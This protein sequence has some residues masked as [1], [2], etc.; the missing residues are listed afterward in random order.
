MTRLQIAIITIAA[1]AFI[2]SF[3]GLSTFHHAGIA[4][5]LMPVEKLNEQFLVGEV[6]F[7]PQDTVS[8]QRRFRKLL[9]DA[10]FSTDRLK[11]VTGIIALQ[12]WIGNQVEKTEPYWGNEQGFQLLM[13]GMNGTGLACSSMSVIFR[14]ALALLETPARIVQIYRSGSNINNTHVL[15]EVNI[16][17]KWVA[18]D[19]TYN[20][21]YQYENE[22][23][24][25]GQI[26]KALYQST[27]KEIELV[28]HGKRKY[29]ASFKA[30]SKEWK[31]VFNNALIAH[32]Q[33][34]G[35]SKIVC[36]VGRIPPFRY[37]WGPQ[38]YFY[39]NGLILFLN[40]HNTLYFLFC[41]VFPTI[42]FTGSALML[43]TFI[44]AKKSKCAES[45]AA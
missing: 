29:P 1:F 3:V 19:P 38:R 40:T 7:G 17:G 6:T 44:V 43:L 11:T 14:E 5:R 4:A 8:D 28:Y 10:G 16:N 18:F 39:G 20:T 21:T 35:C 9:I 34:F 41:A 33:N 27:P 32:N 30:Y 25:I 22:L 15:V 31:F 13:L 23:L 24:D 37:W 26:E 12:T 2:V 45:R 36:W 42:F